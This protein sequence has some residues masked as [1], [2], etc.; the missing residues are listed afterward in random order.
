MKT[1]TELRPLII[2]WATDKNFVKA[3]FAPK[4]RLKLIEECGELASAIL[5]NNIAEQKDAIGDIFVVLV[6]LAEQLGDEI[7]QHYEY[8]SASD[9]VSELLNEI[10]KLGFGINDL[11]YSIS[12]I[13][14][15]AKT[16]NHDLTECANLAW[17]VIKDRTGRTINGSFI[18]D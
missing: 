17:D 15:I 2:Q 8:E 5:K 12:Y 1:L 14:D 16:L 7:Y 9:D 18:K 13:T 3:E 11:E 6:I 10:I 4:Q